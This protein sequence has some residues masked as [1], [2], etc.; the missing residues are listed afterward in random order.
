MTFVFMYWIICTKTTKTEKRKMKTQ[1]KSKTNCG[2]ENLSVDSVLSFNL[3]SDSSVSSDF[4]ISACV[5]EKGKILDGC[6]EFC[7]SSLELSAI[8]LAVNLYWNVVGFS[9]TLSA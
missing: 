8:L 1:M 4:Q 7:D 2:M 6:R 9:L 3:F 5:D